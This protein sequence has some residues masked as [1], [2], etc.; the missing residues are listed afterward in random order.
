MESGMK[1]KNMKMG[2]IQD[3]KDWIPYSDQT[4]GFLDHRLIDWAVSTL[5]FCFWS[6]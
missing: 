6:K 5:T 4:G 3:L 2:V 1:N